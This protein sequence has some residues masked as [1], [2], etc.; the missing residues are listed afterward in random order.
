MHTF[1]GTQLLRA[2]AGSFTFVALVF[3]VQAMSGQFRLSSRT[4]RHATVWLAV[5]DDVRASVLDEKSSGKIMSS[6]LRCRCTQTIAV[7]ATDVDPAV[8]VS[9]CRAVAV[10]DPLAAVGGLLRLV[11]IDGPWAAHLLTDSP[12]RAPGCRTTWCCCCG[13][14]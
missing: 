4:A 9:A 13:G 6:A 2:V 8:R 7:A 14:G 10:I 5:T 3:M 12:T 1:N 11:E